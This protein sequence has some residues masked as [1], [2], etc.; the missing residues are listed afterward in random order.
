[1]KSSGNGDA[2]SRLSDFSQ[3]NSLPKLRDD[4]LEFNFPRA[5]PELFHL[6]ALVSLRDISPYTSYGIFRAENTGDAVPRTHIHTLR[7]ALR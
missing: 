6:H 2:V 1:M 5:Y 3:A 4:F 7:Y